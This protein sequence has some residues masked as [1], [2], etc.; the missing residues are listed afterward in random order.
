MDKC[1]VSRPPPPFF[2][3]MKSWHRHAYQLLRILSELLELAA[4][5]FQV[6]SLDACQPQCRHLFS[7]STETALSAGFVY[8]FPWASQ[9]KP[10]GSPSKSGLI[11][12][13]TV[14][15]LHETWPVA[16]YHADLLNLICS[17]LYSESIL[18][19]RELDGLE[20]DVYNVTM[21]ILQGCFVCEGSVTSWLVEVQGKC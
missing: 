16:D 13:C 11:D 7:L 2:V 9:W 15:A 4:S 8:L 21:K 14:K 18:N 20:Q 6:Q 10:W 1:I 17:L 5:F 12:G 19:M 3:F